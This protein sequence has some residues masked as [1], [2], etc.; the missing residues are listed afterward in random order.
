MEPVLLDRNQP[1]ARFYRGGRR[2]AE[3]RG[4][5]VREEFEPEDWV[6]STTEVTG[7]P[8]VGLS[9]LPD[10][11]LLRDAIAADPEGWLGAEHVAEF[12]RSTEVL[13]KLLDAGE[14]LPVH[15]HPSRQYA[16]EHLD[17]THGKAE[18]WIFLTDGEAHLGF[19]PEV[20]AEQILPLLTAGESAPV[21]ALMHPLSVRAGDVVYCPP[22]VP[23]AIGGGS[24]MVEVQEPSDLSIFLEWKD[25]PLPGGA[26]GHLGLDEATAARAV[27]AGL[28]REVVERFVVARA[29]T[30][31]DL[32]AGTDA[33]FRA[34]RLAAG[35]RLEAGFAVVIVTSG[36]GAAVN[37]A[38]DRL[39]LPQGS[40]LVIPHSWGAVALE[41]GSDL[42]VLVARPPAP[43]A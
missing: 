39:E 12:G 35:D 42:R 11:A 28:E 9:A 43:S 14:R 8:G 17:G 40:T 1:A 37:G 32:L 29:G 25:F 19:L 3:F 2:I 20:T 13:T 4:V 27:V 41:G 23:H 5:P 26:A 10:G 30:T 22:G 24:F 6:G 33:P 38:G 36:Q 7:E 34:D 21:L 31:G 18:A 16:A 15:L